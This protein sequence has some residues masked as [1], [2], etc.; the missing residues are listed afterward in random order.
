MRCRRHSAFKRREILTCY[1]MDEPRGHDAEGTKPGTKDKHRTTALVRGAWDSERQS[2]GAGGRGPGVQRGRLT[3]EAFGERNTAL[4]VDGDGGTAVG[5]SL[6][7]P[8][9][10]LTNG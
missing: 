4:E 9:W 8:N 1:T 7:P 2:G 3:S 5:M 6:M 10:T